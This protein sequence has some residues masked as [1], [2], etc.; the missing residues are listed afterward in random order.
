MCSSADRGGEGSR[1]ITFPKAG[2]SPSRGDLYWGGSNTTPSAPCHAHP[3]AQEA[4]PA[5][6][7]A[8]DF[9]ARMLVRG[10]PGAC[11]ATG[12]LG[13]CGPHARYLRSMLVGGAPAYSLWG[14]QMPAKQCEASARWG[15][16]RQVDDEP[17]WHP[18]SPAPHKQI[19]ARQ[20]PQR[21]AIPGGIYAKMY[22]LINYQLSTTIP[23]IVSP[24]E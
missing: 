6:M 8:W 20:W 12:N 17:T 15:V 18:R 19:I 4:M 7:P 13:L 11:E 3:H 14:C 24:P 5:N 10:R 23:S 2:E 21:T 22:I 9:G 16:G 1:K